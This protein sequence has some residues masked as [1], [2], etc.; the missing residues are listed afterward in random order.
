MG[1][2]AHRFNPAFPAHAGM[3][4]KK[5]PKKWAFYGVPR[6]RGDEPVAVA[7]ERK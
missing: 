3:N 1:A 6:P 4:R 7:K 5:H 2:D